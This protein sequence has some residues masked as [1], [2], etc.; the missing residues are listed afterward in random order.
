MAETSSR[1][2]LDDNN[3]DKVRL[4]A[5]TTD[6]LATYAHIEQQMRQWQTPVLYQSSNPHE[7]LYVALFDGTG[8]DAINDPEH[9]TNV[10]IFN[11]QLRVVAERTNEKVYAHYVEGPGTQSNPV[12][13]TI[14][15]MYGSTYGERLE[16]MYDELIQKSEQW[17]Q[18]DPQAQIR[19]IS[20]GFSRGAEQAAGFTRMVHEQGIQSPR[21]AHKELNDSHELVKVYKAPP[22]I[23]PGQ[24]PQAVGLFDPVAT[25]EPHF[26]DRRLPPSVISGV[27]LY[28]INE[29]RDLFPSST[30]ID[31]GITE[32]G[33]FMGIHALGA[34]SDLG[35]GYQL[36]GLAIRNGNLMVDYINALSDQP[37]LQ[38]RAEPI[39]LERYM[40]H[41]SEDHQ[42]FYMTDAVRDQNHR[43]TPNQQVAQPND[44]E[45]MDVQMR[46][47]F[48]TQSITIGVAPA[49]PAQNIQPEQTSPAIEQQPSLAPRLATPAPDAS[50]Q[51]LF[52]HLYASLQTGDRAAFSAAVQTVT[53]S[54]IGRDMQAQT[55]L[56]VD[57]KEQAMTEQLAQAQALEAQQKME[58]QAQVIRGPRMRM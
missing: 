37:L 50:A 36:D 5:V 31:A 41:H 44:N 38:K 13:K 58:E 51:V 23:R 17:L 1:I 55:V 16:K 7:R 4:D 46:A 28:A 10:G 40:I 34:H 27:Q 26:H 22:L 48:S 32:Q 3:P 15:L 35:G 57:A 42:F 47:Q 9:I 53:Q 20:V 39:Q 11:N 6:D 25:G 49:A 52:D 29:H 30:I 18:E 24:T 19:V 43:L 8:N 21:N 54:D 45:P 56:A 2:T 33:R 14:D 12:I